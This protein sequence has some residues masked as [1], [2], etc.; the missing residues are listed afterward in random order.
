MLFWSP[1]SPNLVKPWSES[2]THIHLKASQEQTMENRG[3]VDVFELF[4]FQKKRLWNSVLE[5]IWRT[6]WKSWTEKL[7]DELETVRVLMMFIGYLENE[8]VRWFWSSWSH[9]VVKH[10]ILD[11][12]SELSPRVRFCGLRF[13]SGAWLVRSNPLADPN[14]LGGVVQ[15]SK[16]EAGS[17]QYPAAVM[18]VMEPS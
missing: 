3:W 4:E 2:L 16:E 8:R 15:P 10:P 5:T 9:S 12:S 7:S 14:K 6:S 11:I 13:P 1:I 18:A 17:S